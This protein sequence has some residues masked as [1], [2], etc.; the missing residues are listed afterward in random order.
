MASAATSRATSNVALQNDVVMILMDDE[1]R[2]RRS[3]SMP[4]VARHSADD[5][6]WDL[7]KGEVPCAKAAKRQCGNM[8]LEVPR[9]RTAKRPRGN[10]AVPD[11]CAKAAKRQRGNLAFAEQQQHQQKHQLMRQFAEQQQK[12]A[13]SEE[14]EEEA[15]EKKV[16]ESDTAYQQRLYSWILYPPGEEESSDSEQEHP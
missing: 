6:T 9:A 16:G 13:E 2:K 15:P 12:Q 7:R 4:V 11:P 14:P 5:E 8:A 10:M 1:N 3:P